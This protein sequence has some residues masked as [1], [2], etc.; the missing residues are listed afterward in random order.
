[1]KHLFLFLFAIL[2][3]SCNRDDFL[4]DIPETNTLNQNNSQDE[5]PC[6]VNSDIYSSKCSLQE[7]NTSFWEPCFV[8]IYNDIVFYDIVNLKISVLCEGEELWSV[9]NNTLY[10]LS[11]SVGFITAENNGCL[12]DSHRKDIPYRLEWI[13][14]IPENKLDI[15]DTIILDFE[16]RCTDGTKKTNHVRFEH[17]FCTSM[18]PNYKVWNLHIVPDGSGMRLDDN[19]ITFKVDLYSVRFDAEVD[20]WKK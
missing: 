6:D 16:I 19:N 17:E 11:D 7:N 20:T 10:L 13:K 5:N 1:M 12:F 3:G 18:F 8:N 14:N 9:T 4:E 2:L 15:A